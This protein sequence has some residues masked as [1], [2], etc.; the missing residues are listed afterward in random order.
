LFTDIEGSTRLWE[1]YPE[2]MPMIQ[3]R[4]DALLHHAV[5]TYGG[6]VYRSAGDAIH[7]VFPDCSSAARAALEA[8][9]ALAAV[10]WDIP[11]GLP[12]RMAIHSTSA[13]PTSAGDYRSAELRWLEDVLSIGHGG[14]T[15][16]TG[17]AASAL[18]PS[19]PDGMVLRELGT[20]QLPEIG[21]PETIVQISDERTRSDFPPLN[22]QRAPI[23]LL[24][25]QPNRFIG[26]NRELHELRDMLDRPG[27]QLITLTG[28]GG[29]GKTRLARQLATELQ[30][31]RGTNVWFVELTGVSDPRLFISTIASTMQLRAVGHK[32]TL[33]MIVET[34]Q[35]TGTILIIDNV[36]H[37][38]PAASDVAD[39][40]R[41]ISDMRIVATSRIPL[42]LHGER[43][44]PIEPLA[45]PPDDY[46]SWE[47]L[48]A[49]EAVQLFLDRAIHALPS[50]GVEPRQATAV[51][52]ICG[53]L[54]GLPLA[55]EL[56]APRVRLLTVEEL[57][58]RLTDRLGLLST[59]DTEFP[60]RHR[61]M[62]AS[63][64]WSYDLLDPKQQWFFRQ[65]AVLQSG[66]TLET[67]EGLFRDDEVDTL[68]L[69]A[70][71]V[72]QQLVQ[73]GGFQRDPD[74]YAMLES[75]RQYA[76]EQLE[77]DGELAS[78]Q[79]RHA[80]Y[81]SELVL[82]EHSDQRSI[83]AEAMER[84]TPV[85]GDIRQAIFWLI[86]HDPLRALAMAAGSWRIWFVMGQNADAERWLGD[87]LDAT[88]EFQTVDRVRAIYGRSLLP[89]STI[90]YERAIEIAEESKLLAIELGDDRGIGDACNYQ[91]GVCYAW[92][93][94]R[95]ESV[96]LMDEALD[97]Y[98]RIGDLHGRAETLLNRAAMAL[99]EGDLAQALADGLEVLEYCRAN[100]KDV[101]ASNT[102]QGVAETALRLG[103]IPLAIDLLVEALE[104]NRR[105]QYDAFTGPNIW[106]A[107]SFLLAMGEF[108]DALRL[109]IFS[110]EF[111]RIINADGEFLDP[112]R[113]ADAELSRL[114]VELDPATIA[115]ATEAGKAMTTAE[116]VADALDLL[117]A[118]RA[119]LDERHIEQG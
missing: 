87:T 98:G 52:G 56:A 60:D 14:Q 51:V 45:V 40:L 99:D 75:V 54:E 103:N 73:R 88:I 116:A 1:Q 107:S 84:F 32:P 25:P 89:F 93:Q 118:F 44:Y 16:L 20:W 27:S 106:C 21:R 92:R 3:A 112:F 65:L 95:A 78:M 12:V 5:H 22:A 19:R 11:A 26:R 42:R 29:I 2:A 30:H 33:D 36:E 66:F 10:E 18:A 114:H 28:P 41:R 64:A 77:A 82:A 97:A 62:R 86:E 67:L 6:A 58:E 4:H 55:I 74:R 46:S 70:E 96:L 108:E 117:L 23:P 43:Q 35:G 115:R 31:E 13:E 79:E 119:S 71:L 57:N 110:R 113:R 111:A 83:D 17:A 100:G 104:L 50:F 90:E 37:L 49:T 59:P 8:Q 91:S 102:I 9:G 38:L 68:D 80:R 15:L 81:F 47:E 85:L 34:L 72:D 24:D 39:L 94:Q 101:L 69:V 76:L 7:A 53:K 48:K 109:S 61:A 105:L 63:I